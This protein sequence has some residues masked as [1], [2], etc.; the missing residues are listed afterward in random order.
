MTRVAFM[1]CS[2]WIQADPGSVQLNR[3]SM[4]QDAW[5]PTGDV[6]NVM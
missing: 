3:A 1:C 4:G 6:L 2:V 5:I